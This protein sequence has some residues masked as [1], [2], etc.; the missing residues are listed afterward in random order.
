[1]GDVLSTWYQWQNDSLVRR[2]E[3]VFD[4]RLLWWNYVLNP[5]WAVIFTL[6][7]RLVVKKGP[8]RVRKEEWELLDY[9]LGRAEFVFSLSATSRDFIRGKIGDGAISRWQAFII[10]RS[11]GCNISKSGSI[12]ASPIGVVGLTVGK[13]VTSVFV[14]LFM[15]VVWALTAELQGSCVRPCVVFGS[16]ELMFV[17]ICLTMLS[18]SLSTG[19]NRGAL[20]L[21]GLQRSQDRPNC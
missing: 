17:S 4:A 21:A 20:T 3:Y 15:L 11:F 14:I 19:R 12:S 5:L 9:Y 6:K 8:A 7:R 18:R 16:F 1:M 2:Y 10:M 13:A